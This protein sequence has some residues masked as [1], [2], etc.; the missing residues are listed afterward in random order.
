MGRYGL[1]HRSSAEPALRVWKV[2]IVSQ[3]PN[4][5]ALRTQNGR[6]DVNLR[7]SSGWLRRR[8]QSLLQSSYSC[9]GGLDVT[10]RR[11]HATSVD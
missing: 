7:T 10:L 5:G 4:C 11:L 2:R 6:R 9:K 8:E 3:G 1:A